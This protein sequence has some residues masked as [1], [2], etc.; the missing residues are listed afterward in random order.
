VIAGTVEAA[1]QPQVAQFRAAIGNPQAEGE[2]LQNIL[3]AGGGAGAFVAAI[4]GIPVGYRALADRYRTEIDAGRIKPTVQQQA[5]LDLLERHANEAESNP[6]NRSLEGTTEAHAANLKAADLA[7]A[8]GGMVPASDLQLPPVSREAGSEV[9]ERRANV[10]KRQQVEDLQAK[11]AAIKARLDS[12]EVSPGEVKA[13]LDDLDT[14]LHTSEKAPSLQNERAFTNFMRNKSDEPVL[15]FDLDNF[16]RI[17][18][19]LSHDVGDQVIRSVGDLAR[20]VADELNIPVF[21]KSGDEFLGSGADDQA[22]KSLGEAIQKRLANADIEVELPNGQTKT[23]KE[24]RLS[25]GVARGKTTQD[26]INAAEAALIADKQRRK[27]AGLRAD[28]SDELPRSQSG[29]ENPQNLVS[30]T[31]SI[32]R[33]VPRGTRSPEEI[34]RQSAEAAAT[35]K[36]EVSAILE[37]TPDLKVAGAPLADDAGNLTS[38]SITARELLAEVDAEAATAREF[39]ACVA[40]S[41]GKEAAA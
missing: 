10:Q 41:T 2:A 34:E 12:G 27:A 24:V 28:R 22:L 20:E 36:A 16:K 14:A 1:I 9:F 6:F 37:T 4:K 19:E 30:E 18:D 8:E 29:R 7:A 26:S 5:A 11:V 25:F 33:T 17:N 31:T 32:N 39:A 38:R 21:H 13:A 35:L 15:F 23:I 40:A 3:L